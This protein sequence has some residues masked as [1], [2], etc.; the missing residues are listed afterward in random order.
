MNNMY[1]I[2]FH[3]RHDEEEMRYAGHVLRGS[4]G[5]SHLQILEGPIEKRE[6]WVLQEGHG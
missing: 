2:T 3:G 1:K 6:R 5:L 4:S